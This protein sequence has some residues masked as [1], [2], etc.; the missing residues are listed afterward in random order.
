MSET[1][2]RVD[3]GPMDH[4]MPTVYTA[5]VCYLAM[6]PGV[7]ATEVFAYLQEGLHRTFLQVPWLSGKVHRQARDTPGWRPGKLEIRYSPST[8]DGP[9]PYQFRFNELE[10]ATHYPD[11]KASAFPLDTFDDKDLLWV[12][13]WQADLDV[14]VEVVVAQANFMPGACLLA[15]GM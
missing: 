15:F 9:Q 4:L 5:A 10:S 1:P 8:A 14:G 2:I 13:T 6:K 12:E 3:L 7:S 11:L